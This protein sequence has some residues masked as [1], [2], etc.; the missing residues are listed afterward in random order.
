MATF[1][2]SGRKLRWKRTRANYGDGKQLSTLI[3]LPLLSIA[4][5]ESCHAPFGRRVQVLALASV[6]CSL[7]MLP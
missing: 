2:V 3:L 1:L 7:A 4:V 5:Q 6:H